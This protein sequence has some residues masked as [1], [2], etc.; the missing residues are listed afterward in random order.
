MV[1]LIRGLTR[2]TKKYTYDEVEE[3]VDTM[4]IRLCEFAKYE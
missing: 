1:M 3:L 4:K 2:F